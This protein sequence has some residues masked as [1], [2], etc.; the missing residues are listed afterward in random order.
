MSC[1]WSPGLTLWRDIN[2]TLITESLGL[3]GTFKDHLVQPSCR[4][5]AQLSQDKAPMQIW[6]PPRMEHPQCLWAAYAT[7]LPLS[8]WR[9]LCIQFKSTL[10]LIVSEKQV[11]QQCKKDSKT[12]SPRKTHELQL[13]QTTT[14]KVCEH[15]PCMLRSPNT[16]LTA[17]ASH[18]VVKE[19]G[20]E[21]V[22]W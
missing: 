14:G 1:Q 12:N 3:E 7:V 17:W 6:T 11:E 8:P 13:G 20:R 16:A 5:Q 2:L 22:A 10:H 18:S 4:G 15:W 21:A 9:I 19:V